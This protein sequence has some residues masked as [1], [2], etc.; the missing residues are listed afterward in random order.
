MKAPIE[1]AKPSSVYEWQV[2]PFGTT[3]SPRCADQARN[4]VNNKL[5]EILSLGGFELYQWAS[6]V[7]SVTCPK[8][9]KGTLAC[10][11]RFSGPSWHFLTDTMKNLIVE[12][13]YAQI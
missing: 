12:C 5:R 13:A 4:L 2:L 9:L 1:R 10:T 6:N 7:P 3:C 8:M 11:S